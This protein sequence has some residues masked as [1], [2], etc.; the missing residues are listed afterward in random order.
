MPQRDSVA[1][2]VFVDGV[3][4]PLELQP[5]LL[6]ES[7]GSQRLDIATLEWRG[8]ILEDLNPASYL[9][10]EIEIQEADTARVVHWGKVTQLPT[11]ISGESGETLELVS[12]TE[13]YHLGDQV[14]GFLVWDPLASDTTFIDGDVVF[15]PMIDG[16][17]LGNLNDTHVTSA[18]CLLFLDPESVRTAAAQ[19][20][21]GANTIHWSLSQAVFYLLW[22]LNTPQTNIANPVIGTLNA[23]FNDP[24]ALVQEVRIPRGHYLPQALDI[25]LEPLG[26]RWR[27]KRTGMGARVYDFWKKGTGGALKSVFHQRLG[28]TLANPRDL[29]QT[30]V[31][32]SG[33]TFDISN[34]ANE[35]TVRGGF[36]EYEVTVE[37]ARGWL[38]TADP[39]L[40]SSADQFIIDGNAN[41]Q[42]VRDVM[43]KW[44]LNE[45][46][47]YIGTRTEIDGVFT[48]VFRG[49]LNSL[50]LL[51]HF[52]PRRRKLLPTLSLKPANDTSVHDLVPIGNLSG[53]EVEYSNTASPDWK[54][55]H[56]L[57]G[58]ECAL[59]EQE[60]G[61]YFGGDKLPDEFFEDIANL[62]VRVTATIQGDFRLT[63]E[64]A[65]QATSP[66]AD[67]VPLT[68]DLPDRFRYRIRHSSLSKYG[69]GAVPS[70]AVNDTTLIQNFATSVRNAFDLM[71]VSGPIQLEGLDHTYEVSDR[72]EKIY[73][74]NISFLCRTSSGAYPQVV[75]I[76]RNI[77]QQLTILHLEHERDAIQLPP[78]PRG[79]S[80]RF[81][82]RHSARNVV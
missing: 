29:N 15:N 57:K 64:V 14:D 80:P 41:F 19:S 22:S 4:S 9:N 71:E 25:L 59:L 56:G 13:L 45:A 35:I 43:R 55:I 61:I 38:A 11:L 75:A 33:I 78:A 44:V 53:V 3:I 12:K 52:I 31:E 82:E 74:K 54:S 40:E 70:T 49:Q 72:I 1:Y 2:N 66:N 47:D 67:V 48:T 20:L 5:M 32:T 65:R 18:G 63:G 8:A 69:G 76:E 7:A 23:I 50:G 26:Y 60:A 51:H 58:G 34:L 39:T 10:L 77:E 27:E 42:T 81:R 17:I 28:N 68:L 6:K 62:R 46:G 37:L 73:G 24:T 16:V 79:N 21:Q 36:E 30:N